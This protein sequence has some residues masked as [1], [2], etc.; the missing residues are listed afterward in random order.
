MADDATLLRSLLRLRHLTQH[1][2]FSAQFER[3]AK[4][5]ANREDDDRLA[6]V[7]VSERQLRRWTAG[8]V[9]TKPLPDTCRVLEAMFGHS[10]QALLS[11]PE[12]PSPDQPLT[13]TAGNSGADMGRTLH[14]AAQR[15]R[16]FSATADETNI[17]HDA[18]SSLRDEAARLAEAYPREPL[19]VLLPDLAAFQDDTLTLLE[20]RQPP[21]FTRDLYMLASLAS[22]MLAKAN[23]DLRSP[24][25]A[26]VH[27][28]LAYQCAN[29]A[30]HNALRAWVRGIESL[31]KYWAGQPR[32]A[33]EYALSGLEIPGV[34]GTVHVWLYALQGRAEAVLGNATAADS[35]VS[36]GEAA[37]SRVQPDDLDSLG[38]ICSFPH[39]RGLYYAADA[40]VMLPAQLSGSPL[41]ARAAGYADAAIKAYATTAEPS[42]G[43]QAGAHAALAIARI[44]S[45]DVDGAADALTPVLSLPSA[46]RINGVVSCVTSVH[47]ALSAAPESSVAAETQQAIEAFCHTPAALAQ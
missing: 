36:L 29:N 28:R 31:I 42:F 13:A 6:K 15:A 32:E 4:E 21:E 30:E 12:P 45:G 40:G 18:L 22:G 37:R 3:A 14:M 10:V 9:T 41:A 19:A 26:M 33:R 47:R 11:T 23:H 38:G 44:R 25:E 46:M 16:Q 8:N 7:T 27:A 20:G 17:G 34:T 2:A 35:A 5:L 43:D 1:A 39:E 24:R